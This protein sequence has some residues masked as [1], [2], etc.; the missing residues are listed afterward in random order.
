VLCPLPATAQHQL[1]RGKRAKIIQR[2]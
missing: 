1:I 2:Q